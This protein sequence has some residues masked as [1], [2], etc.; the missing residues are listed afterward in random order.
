M[1]RCNGLS[2]RGLLGLL[3]G[4]AMAVCAAAG[5]A[6]GGGDAVHEDIPYGQRIQDA[7]AGFV[8]GWVLLV[9][10]LLLLFLVEKQAVTFDLI[11]S[12]CRKATCVLEEATVDFEGNEG[13]AVFVQGVTSA[14]AGSCPVSDAD[15]GFRY[16]PSA[17]AGVPPPL[18]LRLRREVAMYQWV[19]HEKSEEKEKVYTYRMEWSEA[20][21]DSSR[22]RHPA[23]HRNPPREPPVRSETRAPAWYGWASSSSPRSWSASCASGACAPCRGAPT[24][25]GGGWSAR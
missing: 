18:P 20:D 11:M 5:E 7:L 24:R 9:F 12:R 2:W 6:G 25:T 1:L 21:H 4:A 13:R 15:T 14:V 19:E 17:A 23:G 22:F 3:A 10:S 8:C 16:Q